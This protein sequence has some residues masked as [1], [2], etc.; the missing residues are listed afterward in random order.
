VRRATGLAIGAV[1]A[2]A[3]F[4]AVWALAWL[5][6]LAALAFFILAGVL[7]SAGENP[8]RGPLVR[9]FWIGGI[10]ALAITGAF[11]ALWIWATANCLVMCP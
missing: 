9:G 4:A 11:W 7:V 2:T 6:Y 3:V 10:G 5:H 1:A 8:P